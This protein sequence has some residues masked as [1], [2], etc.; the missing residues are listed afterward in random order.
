MPDTMLLEPFVL[1]ETVVPGRPI[2]YAVGLPS[3]GRHVAAYR[4]P[5][6]ACAR[7][8]FTRRRREEWT[9]TECGRGPVLL[10]TCCR[11][12]IAAELQILRTWALLT[13]GVAP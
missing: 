9:E 8:H 6:A 7:I 4:C 13:L 12:G 10:V 2:V 1:S 5:Y 3:A 11:A